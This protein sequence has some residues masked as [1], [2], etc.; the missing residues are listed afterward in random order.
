MKCYW[1]EENIKIGEEYTEFEDKC[2]HDQ[3]YDEWEYITRKY[4]INDK[5]NFEN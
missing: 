2:F 4:K 5:E 3:C 1:C